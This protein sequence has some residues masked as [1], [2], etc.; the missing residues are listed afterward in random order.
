MRGIT[1][2]PAGSSAAAAGQ[3]QP[4]SGIDVFA[5]PGLPGPAT[6]DGPLAAAAP[7]GSPAAGATALRRAATPVPL[8][9]T[10][11]G[12][13]GSPA[14]STDSGPLTLARPRVP[15]QP[16]ST[17]AASST[18]AFGRITA[19]APAPTVQASS[20]SGGTGSTAGTTSQLPT[21]TAT[22]VVQRVEGAAP[23]TPAREGHTDTELDELA[24]AI[25]GR[26]RNHLRTEVIHEREAKGLTFD[27]F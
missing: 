8:Q 9:R 15:L 4:L 7:A 11:A 5:G 16:A 1:F 3:A 23:E 22:P 18:P 25:F 6:V 21:F 10:P 24:K 12:A 26:I 19:D 2:P 17:T 13:A 14:R 27:A 20:A